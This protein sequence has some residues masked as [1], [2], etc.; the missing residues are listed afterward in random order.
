M[1]TAILTL[2]ATILFGASTWYLFNSNDSSI[3]ESSS[4][5]SVLAPSVLGDFLW[6]DS[7]HDGIQDPGEPGLNGVRVHLYT[8]YVAGTYTVV[9]QTTTNVD[10][11][12]IFDDTNSVPF[13]DNR[14]YYIVVEDDINEP[15]T[16][17][18]TGPTIP[19]AGPIGPTQDDFDSDAFIAN[20]G[21]PFDGRPTIVYTT[22]TGFAPIT[23]LD[24]GFYTLC[25]GLDV[26]IDLVDEICLGGTVRLNVLVDGGVELYGYDWSD[27]F[28]SPD[29]YHD[30]SPTVNTTYTVT[31]TDDL[32]CTATSSVDTRVR[33]CVLDLALKKTIPADP[34]Y[35]VGD[36]ATFTITVCNQG[37]T[38]VDSIVIQDHIPNGYTLVDPAWNIVSSSSTY[39]NANHT[40]TINNGKLPAEGLISGA[41]IEVPINLEI[42]VG[43]N[44]ANLINYA[45]IEAQRDIYGFEDDIDSTPGSGTPEEFSVLPGDP[46]DDNMNTGGPSVNEDEDD[47]DPAQAPFFDLA[48]N[49]IV[50]T[51]GP[52]KYGDMLTFDITV[53][54]QGNVPATDIVVIDYVP[55]GLRFDAL[56]APLWS[57]DSSSGIATS[58]ITGVLE[59]GTSITLP[60]SLEVV[61][62]ADVNGWLNKAEIYAAEDNLGIDRTNDDVDS[63]YDNNPNNDIGG[64]PLTDEDNHVSDDGMDSDGDGITD[65]DDEDPE[66][67]QVFDL[68]L[69]KELV[70]E[71]PYNYGQ[72]LVFEITVCNQGNIVAKDIEI[73]DYVP[74]GLEY[75]PASNGFLG[76][77]GSSPTPVNTNM[78]QLAPGDC[79][80]EMIILKM[81]SVLDNPLAWNN[82]AEITKAYDNYLN[83]MTNNDADST[84]GSN[85]PEE[86]AVLPG[87]PDDNNMNGG[88]PTVGE[89]EDDHDPAGPMFYDLALRKTTN[90]TGPFE[91]G[92]M[93][94][95][96]IT[97]F[98][99]GNLPVTDVSV[100]DYIPSG[101]AFVANNFPTW[102][103]D[104]QNNNASSVINYI[105][106]GDSVKVNILLEFK[107]SQTPVN[108]WTNKAEISSFKDV[109]GIDVSDQDIDST[110]D[111]NPNNDI[112][113][114]PD[115][116][117]DNDISDDGFDSNGDGVRDED[118]EDPAKLN[119]FDLALKKVLVSTPP[120][121]YGDLLH[122]QIEVYNQ[123]NIAATNVVIKDYLPAGL[124]IDLA[125]NPGWGADGLYTIT[126][127]IN[128]GDYSIVDLYLTFNQTSG[129]AEDWLNYSEI[130]SSEDTNGN[131]TTNDDADS[132]ANSNSPEERAVL[133]GSSDDN[134]IDS[135]GPNV[136][137]DQDDSDP[138]G[139]YFGD[140]ALIKTVSN[141]GP[142]KLNNIVSFTITVQN[143]GNLEIPQVGIIDYI[144]SGLLPI[145]SNYPVW[146]TNVAQTRAE[147]VI[148]NLI[149]GETRNITISFRVQKG[150]GLMTD[151]DNYAEIAFMRDD[152]GNNIPDVDSTPDTNKN[153]DIGGTIGTDE[154]NELN[155]DG[156]DTNQDGVTDED[157][158]DPE[159]IT[160]FDLALRKTMA[161]VMPVSYGDLVTFNI[162]VFNQGNETAT[163]VNVEDYIPAG[164][165]FDSA[166]NPDWSTSALGATYEFP[167]PI[168]P[169]SSASVD[170]IL[171]VVQ[172]SGGDKDW[173]NYAEIVSAANENG[174]D[175]TNNDFDS[176]PASNSAYERE[177]LPNSTFDNVI[178]G[179]GQQ[180]NEDEDD[181]DPAGFELVDLALKKT[182]SQSGPF[183]AGDIVTFAITVYNQGST[184]VADAGIVDHIP[185]GFE[186]MSDNFPTWVA[187]PAGNVAEA[188]I[189]N[190]MPGQSVTLNIR[191]KVKKSSSG[192]TAWDNLAEIYYE[193]DEAGNNLSDVD[194]T[195]DSI[196]GNDIGGTIGTSE[197]NHVDDDGQDTNGDGITDEDDQDPERI[198]I[199]DLALIKQVDMNTTYQYGD[200]VPFEITIF[201]QGN[202]PVSNVNI[203]DHLPAGFGF[204]A[205]QNPDW[206]L[207]G[208]IAEYNYSNTLMPGSDDTFTIYLKF[209]QTNGGE[210]DWINYAEIASFE[211]ING[212][213]VSSYDIDS[214]PD[215]YTQYEQDV[216]PGSEFDDVITGCGESQGEDED[217]SDPAGF[218]IVDLALKKTT[219]QTG[220]FSA[221]DIVTF[222]ITVYNQGST[223]VGDVGIV[224]HIPDGF[225]FMFDNFPI[226]Y[227]NPTG[228]IAVASIKNL[229]PG[230]SKVLNIRLKVKKSS[231]GMTAWD[232]S[233]EIYYER[234]E[235]GND[236]TDVDST[237]DFVDGNDIGGTI[238]TSEDNH[239]ADD[240]QDSNGD[241]ITDEDDQDPERIAVYDLALIKQVDMD[242]I[243]HYGDIIPFEITLY[244]QG[245]QPVTN[246]NV[247]DHIPVGY[248][249]VASQ[250]PNW[251]LSGNIAEYNF[252]STL[253][254]GTE[255]SFNIYLKLLQTSGGER[256]WVN[257]AEI[258][259]FQDLNG[260][261]MSAYDIDSTPDSYTQY[262]QDVLPGSEF[263]D[264][265]TG[266]GESQGED[267]DDSDPAGVMVYDLALS[268][269]ALEDGPYDFFQVVEYEITVCNQG[270]KAARN[271]DII[272]YLPV[273][274]NYVSDN[275]PTWNYNSFDKEAVTRIMGPLL[276]GDCQSITIMLEVQKLKNNETAWD[277]RAEIYSAKDIDF[278]LFADIDSN[279]DAIIGNDV[280]GTPWTP[281]DDHIDDDS[282]DTNGDGITDEDDED[283]ARI[284]IFDLAL[285]KDLVTQG[286]YEY[287][288]V[289]RF[290][291]WVFNQ[292]NEEAN[293]IQLIDYMPPGYQFVASQNPGWTQ[294]GQNLLYTING[295][296]PAVDSTS[297][298]LY[299]K[300]IRTNGGDK[301]WIN[302]TEILHADGRASAGYPNRDDW[303]VDSTPGSNSTWETNV[304]IPPYNTLLKQEFPWDDEICGCG[305]MYGEDEDDHDPAGIEIFDLALRKTT[306][307]VPPTRYGDV[308][309][310][311]ITVFN[312]GSLDAHDIEV[313]DYVPCGFEF[314]SS[315]NPS[316]TYN[317]NT[318][319]AKTTITQNLLAGSSTNL[320]IRLMA[321]PCID[322]SQIA[323]TNTSEISDAKTEPMFVAD[324]FDS[325]PDDRN[326]D[327]LVINNMIQNPND[328]DDHDI[329]KIDILDL[330]LRKTTEDC[331]PF[332]IGDTVKFDITVFNQGNINASNIVVVDSISSGFIYDQTLNSGWNKVGNKAYYNFGNYA[333]VPMDSAK[334]SIRFVITMDDNPFATDWW[335]YS[336]ISSESNVGGT[337]TVDADSN[338]DNLIYND[339]FVKPNDSINGI[340]DE[341][342][343]V[344]DEN[345]PVYGNVDEGNDDEDDSDPAKV[346]VLGGLGDTVWKDENGDGLQN[347]DEP[348]VARVDVYLYN[349]QDSLIDHQVT[350]VNGFYFFDNLIQGQYKLKFGLSQ[351]PLGCAFTYQDVGLD[352]T[353][354]SD[355]NLDGYTTCIDVRAGVYDSTWDAGLLYLATVGDRV[356]HDINGNGLQDVSEPG[357]PNVNVYLFDSDNQLVAG[358]LT[359]AFG[360]YKFEYVY[361]GDYYLYFDA[362]EPYQLT[363]SNQGSNDT[364]D[365]DPD[366]ATSRTQIFTLSPG[367]VDLTWDAGYYIC[368]P[369]GD[370]IWY[371]VNYNDLFDEEENGIDGLEIKL[372]KKIGSQWEVWESQYTHH[373][374]NSPSD[375]GY[376]QFCAPPGTYYVE[377]VIPPYGLVPA[378]KDV[379]GYIP[380]TNSYEH[381]NDNDLNYLGKSDVFTVLSGDQVNNLDGGY[382]PQAKAGNLVWFD[383]N[384][385]GI[386][387]PSEP[388][389]GGVI[390]QAY[391]TDNEMAG[392]AVTNV[393]GEYQIGYLQKRAYYFKFIPPT[394][395]GPTQANMTTENMDSDIDNSNGYL[396]TKLYFFNPE[397]ELMN[398]DGGFSFSPLPVTWLDVRVDREGDS[399]KVTWLV[400][401]EVNV[402]N[403]EIFRLDLVNNKFESIDQIDNIEDGKTDHAYAYLDTDSQD[404]GTYTYFIR[405]YDID[406]KFNDSKKVEIT[407]RGENKLSLYP[408]P[409]S[410]ATR[411][412]MYLTE[413]TQISTEL[414][415][416]TGKVI[417]S[418]LT[419]EHMTKGEN[420]IYYNFNDLSAGVYS[421]RVK[422][423]NYSEDKK[424]IIVR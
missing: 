88:G 13:E 291:V 98:N 407:V 226:W 213:D 399:N 298:P 109:E 126:E 268:K 71:G 188:S 163:Q 313:T 333:L 368:I 209:L 261:D 1:K 420:T 166:L 244:N 149:P 191:L 40:L 141:P 355:V 272:D 280:G 162:E 318:R 177:V 19:N 292:G 224:D 84:P 124:G 241:G 387:D 324:D 339:N 90:A 297:V 215:S 66:L 136:D 216:L 41:C 286:P 144:P 135:G 366:E 55:S 350:D 142:Y 119:V 340:Y 37:E 343:D 270:N 299:L 326:N 238:G 164:F 255:D 151:W 254:P 211:D 160:I 89:D 54:N 99:Q 67:I 219:S 382:Y 36:V 123:G 418:A 117:E 68:A 361:P 307:Q 332:A 404:A 421:L 273:G 32:G 359:D 96:T 257:Y 234:D 106:P 334:V 202:Q 86:M 150:A 301:F 386:Q 330:A 236:L 25:S 279:A 61:S 77:T 274:L 322:E 228:N 94:N 379:L 148:F 153:N 186:F 221:G 250:N 380:L 195:P 246:V 287:D 199:Y 235:W 267:E 7:N 128:P 11:V 385:D 107:A 64:T 390:V 187:N 93:A 201:N 222:A 281:E 329:E 282:L 193:K 293:H 290:D 171:R 277:N 26:N 248:G 258:A 365:S 92:E 116:P 204:I 114:T 181:H 278:N 179:C 263:D 210:R 63:Q 22:T 389:M 249:F 269:K 375:D 9:G 14:T 170:I 227:A 232:N 39:F 377:V 4:S 15:G 220:P 157:D 264:V 384:E 53:F 42:V 411:L 348:G 110:P 354:D 2:C 198:A 72:D 260:N 143:Q 169:A 18:P 349:C 46:N 73:S 62:T 345:W 328:E 197:D 132:Q 253:M 325:T 317:E 57:Y 391:T 223:T 393:N 176:T 10:G 396:T 97:V 245:N 5:E 200:I 24:F 50:T 183:S 6:Y 203:K 266:C 59:P 413:D 311:N 113:G 342:D 381:Q 206:T 410:G 23:N 30:V 112:G 165:E 295:P 139:F 308:I 240:G 229:M 152:S 383:S 180:E 363:F 3:Q 48:L 400:T 120:Y 370:L 256:D 194:S 172:T 111:G 78:T 43:A 214:T 189:T 225:E 138:A 184:T 218:F 242:A 247:K 409:S 408:N 155:D 103:F 167:N 145:A 357:I 262:E 233:A 190:L 185:D 283:V 276:P 327:I 259:S 341:N 49:K 319:K 419:D 367:E 300:I 406:G 252:S 60:I 65:E 417:K 364:K 305:P 323:W 306:T 336:E 207:S 353:I 182:T 51:P 17:N 101:F 251:S 129:G 159:R 29:P 38:T 376:Y 265:I 316:W 134:N 108:A 423:G 284:E 79:Q 288:E 158:A 174:I 85:T 156:M 28:S 312:Q 44:P 175:R 346:L 168:L 405:Q 414:L 360:Y 403:Y 83:D 314:V 121:N 374:P 154:D 362:P 422:I 392:T 321:I 394:N 338:P 371:D 52:Y 320:S 358:T 243:Y 8:S 395:N 294:S 35:K 208:S 131:D 130:Y 347:N 237:P 205:G 105:A 12:Y 388:R 69:K 212:N 74:E 82:Y 31:V 133:P 173:I 335:N 137:E 91:Y 34:T 231:D 337:I 397:E 378:V 122:Y 80:T 118:D 351:L 275:F 125:G 352:D 373:K 296:L 192:M 230:Q 424:L 196:V 310:F 58:L 70:T 289:V 331:G 344:I 140:V 95:F 87:S 415:D 412:N 271:I 147:A 285:R 309:Q 303:D 161:A 104:S 217:D 315:L 27:G 369:I 401:D 146:E 115:T 239:V 47:S 20:G 102:V 76:W 178:N 21:F 16:F 402:D 45:E 81:V 398:I 33:R 75:N 56:N 372:W 304:E 100:V 302:Y 416:A 127:I 356:W